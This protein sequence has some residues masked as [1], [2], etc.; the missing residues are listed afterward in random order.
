MDRGGASPG[1]NPQSYA[2]LQPSP[3]ILQHPPPL[4]IRIPVQL[5]DL[6]EVL[7]FDLG[8]IVGGNDGGLVFAPALEGF[9][10][11]DTRGGV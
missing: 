9:E 5:P 10:Y 8:K 6:N 7:G 3:K 1:G 4:H 11:Q 2:A